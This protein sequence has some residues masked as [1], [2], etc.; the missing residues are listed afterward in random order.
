MEAMMLPIAAALGNQGQNRVVAAAPPVPD[1]SRVQ[2][3]ASDAECGMR[4]LTCY[5]CRKK[6]H[7]QPRCRVLDG[8]VANGHVH[9]KCDEPHLL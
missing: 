3:L 2:V 9:L 7:I 1:R 4:D 8:V 6:G 5:F